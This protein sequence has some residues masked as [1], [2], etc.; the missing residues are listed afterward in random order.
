MPYS[1]LYCKPQELWKVV[2]VLKPKNKEEEKYETNENGAN[3]RA[4]AAVASSSTSS[5]TDPA[6]NNAKNNSGTAHGKLA[7]TEGISAQIHLMERIVVLLWCKE[8]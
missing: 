1:K 2:P 8:R 6:N 7:M 4:A 5:N 3:D